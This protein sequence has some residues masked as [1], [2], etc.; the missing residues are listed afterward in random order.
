LESLDVD[1]THVMEEGKI[2][3]NGDASLVETINEKGFKGEA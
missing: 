3:K 2:V 1:V